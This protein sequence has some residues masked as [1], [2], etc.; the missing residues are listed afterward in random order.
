METLAETWAEECTLTH[1]RREDPTYKN[2][3]Q[4]IAATFGEESV[5][6][7]FVIRYWSNER[8]DYDFQHNSC[9]PGKKCGHYTQVV[10]ANTSSVGCAVKQC[11]DKFPD[12]PRPA[13]VYVCQY[14]PRGNYIGQKP[15]EEGPSCQKCPRGTHCRNKLCY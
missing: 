11:D 2:T 14:S 6:F 15:Y 10:W 13:H 3:G 9:A 1:P 8:K 4:N 5:D 7:E 12:L